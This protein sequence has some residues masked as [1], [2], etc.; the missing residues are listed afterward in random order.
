MANRVDYV[1]GSERR[2]REDGKNFRKSGNE[3]KYIKILIALYL[4]VDK[5]NV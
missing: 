4:T 2:E 1:K 3:G 5:L